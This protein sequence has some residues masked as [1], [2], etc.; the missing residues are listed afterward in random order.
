MY[1]VEIFERSKKFDLEVEAIYSE[2]D[3]I[4]L[5]ELLNDKYF[6]EK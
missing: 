1:H 6:N 5:Q 4:K 2:I 3:A